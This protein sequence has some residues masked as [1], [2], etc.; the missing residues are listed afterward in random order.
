MLHLPVSLSPTIL[1]LRGFRS[2][3]TRTVN[4]RHAGSDAIR[5]RCWRLLR[6]R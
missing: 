5:E 4:M 3:R 1:Q 6:W 2:S